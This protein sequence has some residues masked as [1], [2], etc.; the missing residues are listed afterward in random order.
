MQF[1]HLKR[2]ELIA[3]L[4]GAVTTWPLGA[5]AQQPLEYRWAEATMIDFHPWPPIWF[6]VK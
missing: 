1:D 4:G 6:V 2:R 3:L 5:R